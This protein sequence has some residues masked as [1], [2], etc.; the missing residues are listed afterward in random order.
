MI[1]PIRYRMQESVDARQEP[2]RRNG[3]SSLEAVL[4]TALVGVL[5]IA[6]LQTAG[7]SLLRQ[8]ATVDHSKSL[9]LAS[10]LLSEIQSLSYSDPDDDSHVLGP[11]ALE[12]ASDKTT[13]DDVDDF[14]LWVESPPQTLLGETMEMGDAWARQVTVQWVAL[15]NQGD[16]TTSPIETGVKMITVHVLH[17]GHV[18][19]TQ[20]ALKVEL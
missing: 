8:A 1:P 5:M 4:S 12:S 13:F 11:D 20:T 7:Q 15:N 2:F 6:A 14:H 19:E 10:S 18:I 17:N 9:W 3:F 16:W